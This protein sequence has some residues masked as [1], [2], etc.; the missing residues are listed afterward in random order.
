MGKQR[1]RTPAGTAA[2]SR[3]RLE[4]CDSK[5]M[6]KKKTN[7]KPQRLDEQEIP[8]RLREIMKSR[9]ELKNP[10]KKKKKKRVTEQPKL[11]DDIPVPKFRR[12]E[13]ESEFSYIERMEQETQHVLFLTKNQMQ[14]EPEKEELA[15]QKTQKKKEFQKKKLDKVR[16]HKEEKR[17]AM[18]EKELL[19][20]SVKFGEVV[21]Q[22][23]TLTARPRKSTIKNKTGQKQLLLTSLL[24]S[25]RTASTQKAPCASF[26][27]QR[28]IQEERER[29]VQAYRD[30]KKRKQQQQVLT[31]S[32]TAVGNLKKPI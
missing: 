28:I 14:R 26:A 1:L 22:P 30:I 31:E 29:V 19:R 5:Q 6:K 16:K 4:T 21:L 2:T 20:D 17:A 32:Q 25:G 27:R 7:S 9:D 10:K 24:G 8:Y 18:L 23:P 13:G 11:E 3:K 12:Q 15:P